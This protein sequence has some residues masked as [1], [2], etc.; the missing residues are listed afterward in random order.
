MAFRQ[1]ARPNIMVGRSR[2]KK[3][4]ED[5]AHCLGV[6][7]AT[8]VFIKMLP[9]GFHYL[10]IISSIKDPIIFKQ[11]THQVVEHVSYVNHDSL[12]V[13]SCIIKLKMEK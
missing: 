5:K 13:I 12:I 1:V 6:P 11:Q 8:C 3:G 10:L 2:E 7:P 4:Q 9:L